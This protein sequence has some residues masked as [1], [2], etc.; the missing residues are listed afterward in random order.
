MNTRCKVRVESVKLA[1]WD[2]E[3]QTHTNEIVQFRAVSGDKV[4]G[5]YPADGAD[6]DNTYA[7]FSPDADFRL[8]VANP[9]LL[10]QFRPEQRF[11]IDMTEA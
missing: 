3:K 6:E 4:T 8:N 11:Y 10:G 5:G 9:A 7:R 2:T 1:G